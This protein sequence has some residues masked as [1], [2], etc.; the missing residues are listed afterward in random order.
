[1]LSPKDIQS[2][3]ACVRDLEYVLKHWD[4]FEACDRCERVELDVGS[5]T[6]GI[7]DVEYGLCLNVFDPNTLPDHIKLCM[8]IAWDMFSGDPTYPVGGMDEYEG[9]DNGNLYLNSDRK[10]LALHCVKYLSYL[11]E[12]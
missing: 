10:D 2:I 3:Q 4:Y 7:V 5:T 11:L 8:F 12:L 1:M 6:R 9:C